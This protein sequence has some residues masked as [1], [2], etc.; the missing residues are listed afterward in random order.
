MTSATASSAAVDSTGT[1]YVVDHY[2]KQ[3]VKLARSG[4]QLA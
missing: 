2:N 4:P 1:V 3:V